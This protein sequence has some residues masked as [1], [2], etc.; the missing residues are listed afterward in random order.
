VKDK[1]INMSTDRR[2][3][4]DEILDDQ[5]YS[6]EGATPPLTIH[7]IH[8]VHLLLLQNPSCFALMI[9]D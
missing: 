6:T 1:T 7:S 4:E 8:V 5:N 9:Y 2:V 3:A